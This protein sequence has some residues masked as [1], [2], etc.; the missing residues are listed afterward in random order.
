MKKGKK[1]VIIIIVAVVVALIVIGSMAGGDEPTGETQVSENQGVESAAPSNLSN[2]GDYEVIIDSCRLSES[3]DGKPVVIVKYIFTNSDDDPSA[4]WT[5]IEDAVFQDGI[6]LNE[7]YLVTDSANYSADNQIKEIRK[8]ATLNVEVAYEL[9]D[10]ETDIEVEVSEYFS[11]TD[12]KVT[13]IF[14]IK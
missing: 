9:N 7:C 12:R 11:F 10:T 13:K 2:L 14:S 4:F 6:G 3:Y 1:K 5:S 8:G